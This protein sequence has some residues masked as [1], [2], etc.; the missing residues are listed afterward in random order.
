MSERPKYITL[1][2]WIYIVQL[3]LMLITEFLDHARLVTLMSQYWLPVGVQY[4]IQVSMLMVLFCCGIGM[5]Y[6]RSWARSMCIFATLVNIVVVFLNHQDFYLAASGVVWL[7][8]LM[9]VLSRRG[10]REYFGTRPRK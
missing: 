3:P 1:V 5:L 8:L 10:A 7:V 2:A 9:Y 6:G 4:S